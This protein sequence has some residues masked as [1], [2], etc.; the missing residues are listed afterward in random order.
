MLSISDVINETVKASDYYYES[1][2][3]PFLNLKTRGHC[4]D[5]ASKYQ[6]VHSD[7][8]FLYLNL[9]DDEA[10]GVIDGLHA[11]GNERDAVI[12]PEFYP[13]T[14]EERL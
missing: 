3:F 9:S 5:V 7:Y 11:Y 10:T 6:I 14:T 1:C 8:C 13:E 12:A 4:L 2:L